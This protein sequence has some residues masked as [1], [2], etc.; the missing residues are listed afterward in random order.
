MALCLSRQSATVIDCGEIMNFFNHNKREHQSAIM[1]QCVVVYLNGNGP[2]GL[3][4]GYNVIIPTP[5]AEMGMT[6]IQELVREGLIEHIEQYSG[7]SEA[8]MSLV[9]DIDFHFC[10]GFT[11]VDGQ[12]LVMMNCD[13]APAD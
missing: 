4:R 5:P 2:L 11:V 9:P 6:E 3:F 8:L 1:Q 12:A 13:C 10:Y 7:S